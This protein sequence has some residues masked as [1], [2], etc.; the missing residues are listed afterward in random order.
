VYI[1]KSI[2]FLLKKWY[3]TYINYI[4]RKEYQMKKLLI[5]LFTLTSLSAFGLNI[6]LGVN[7]NT[8][9]WG[10]RDGLT[11]KNK[12]D[13]KDTVI[14]IQAEATQG[15]LIGDLGVGISYEPGYERGSLEF[16][17]MPMYLI[18]RLNLFPVGV[19]PYIAVK[20]GKVEYSGDVDDSDDYYALAAG[21]TLI[22]SLQAE[23]S[24]SYRGDEDA[25]SGIMTISLSY[26]VF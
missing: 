11:V 12:T 26:I 22:N 10:K 4:L 18:G 5:A 7:S 23:A 16:D 21:I 8:G 24:Y 19:K 13:Y 2:V 17:Q 9:S 25:G 3:Y 6:S 1:P 14:G 20:V 15:F